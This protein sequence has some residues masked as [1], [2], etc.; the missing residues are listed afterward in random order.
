MKQWRKKSVYYAIITSES[1]CLGEAAQ[2]KLPCDLVNAVLYLENWKRKKQPKGNTD[3]FSKK[4]A[5][6]W[7]MLSC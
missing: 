4:H 7:E 3:F 6:L 2:Q 1:H 5:K